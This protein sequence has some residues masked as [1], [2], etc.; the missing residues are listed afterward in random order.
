MPNVPA[1][2]VAIHWMYFRSV[3]EERVE[4]RRKQFDSAATVVVHEEKVK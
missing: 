1:A 3:G 4:D 2:G